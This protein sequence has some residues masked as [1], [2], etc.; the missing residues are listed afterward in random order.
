MILFT[1]KQ[2]KLKTKLVNLLKNQIFIHLLRELKKIS[3]SKSIL[4]SQFDLEGNFLKEWESAKQAAQIL[5]N[6][7]NGSDIRACIKGIQKTAY[8]YIWK[9]SPKQ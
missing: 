4:I 3:K 2:T 1:S 8:G 7:P 6:K 5:K 9:N